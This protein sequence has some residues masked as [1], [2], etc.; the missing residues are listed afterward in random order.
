MSAALSRQIESTMQRAFE[1]LLEDTFSKDHLTKDDIDWIIRLCKELKKRINDLTPSRM[2]LHN[3]FDKSFD[4]DLIQQ[5]LTNDAFD[6]SDL[7][8]FAQTLEQKLLSLCAPAHDEKIKTFFEQFR[9]G[10]NKSIK[11]VLVE[12]N[13]ILNDIYELNRQYQ[14]F[15]RERQRL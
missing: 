9:C 15:L 3:D 11:D 4:I 14:L 12:S 10:K 2:D 6:E 5:M 13:Q 8:S 1:S 7:L